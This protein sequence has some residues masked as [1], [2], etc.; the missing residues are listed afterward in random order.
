MAGVAE[1]EAPTSITHQLSALPYIARDSLDDLYLTSYI[2]R[3]KDNATVVHGIHA[4]GM[5]KNL[6]GKFDYWICASV[7][8]TSETVSPAPFRWKSRPQIVSRH[9]E[10]TPFPSHH[11]L[12]STVPEPLSTGQSAASK[13]MDRNKITG[14]AT[15][16]GSPRMASAVETTL[17]TIRQR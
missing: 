17:E 15:A 11:R 16:V 8:Q 2:T 5:Y 13:H 7:S 1:R 9:A 4:Q 10:A 3:F 14:L 12:M 6:T